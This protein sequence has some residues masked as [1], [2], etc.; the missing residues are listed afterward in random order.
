MI[1]TSLIAALALAATLSLLA[2][3]G[4]PGPID[5]RK[6]LS[7]L[8][9]PRIASVEDTLL[10][11]AKNAEATGDFKKA[12]VTYQQLLE[13]KPDDK[14][15]T[16]AMAECLRRGGASDKAIMV[17]DQL[18][19]KD[20][21]MIAAKESKGLALIALG[22][23]ETPTPLFEEVLKADATRWKTLNALGILFSTRNLQ[24]EAQQYFSEALKH[25][26]DSA[27]VYNNLGL[28]QALTR[29]FDPA[30]ASLEKAS[31]L[32]NSAGS[33]RKRIDLNLALVYASAG[34]IDDARQIAQ[35]HLEGA[36]LKNN[37]GLYAHLAHDDQMARAYL[38]MALMESKTYYA[39]AWDNLQ[40]IA[41]SGNST[42]PSAKART[43]RKI[44][45]GKKTGSAPAANAQAAPAAGP[46]AEPAPSATAGSAPFPPLPPLPATE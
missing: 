8:D 18:L 43:A 29:K 1:R 34:K 21:D 11:S 10:E 25:K 37:L 45:T 4:G 20:P 9:G 33:E 28:S 22:D 38:N 15:L 30:I 32:A 2:C 23:F 26:A 44:I 35:M 39:R 40:E 3:A 5:S 7:G 6:F 14:E 41:A 46:A 27:T 36:A 12:L 16:F 24:A 13:K 31:A 17:Y 42:K 19:A